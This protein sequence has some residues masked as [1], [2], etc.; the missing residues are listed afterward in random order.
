MAFGGMSFLAPSQ[1]DQSR[2]P[3]QTA[4]KQ[5]TNNTQ[6]MLQVPETTPSMV[7]A[8]DTT[9]INATIEELNA[10]HAVVKK[11]EEEKV[12]SV[13]CCLS[14]ICCPCNL[15]WCI[16]DA[17]FPRCTIKTEKVAPK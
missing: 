1:Y 4:H 9:R 8:I 12:M 14:V 6:N 13:A 5:H 3:S 10:H 17:C 11:E 16:L 2:V 15:A 7:N